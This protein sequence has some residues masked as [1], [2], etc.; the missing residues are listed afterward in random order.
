MKPLIIIAL[1]ICAAWKIPTAT[2]NSSG[3]TAALQQANMMQDTTE[4]MRLIRVT[5]DWPRALVQRDIPAVERI[6]APSN[7]LFIESDGVH[8]NREQYLA[9]ISKAE[10]SAVE[11]T[12]R[13]ARLFGEIGLVIGRSI[14]SGKKN[15]KAYKQTYD[16][17]NVFQKQP[18]GKWRLVSG[19]MTPETA[20]SN[21][22]VLNPI[23]YPK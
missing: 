15:G 7:V 18:D 13:K 21:L 17:T 16:I 5:D 2:K 14:V 9:R 22:P 11:Y 8:M 19:H 4:E 20:T 12:Y 6:I 23:K 3:N 1:A 10:L